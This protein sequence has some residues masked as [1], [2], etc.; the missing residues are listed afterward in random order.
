VTRKNFEDACSINGVQLTQAE[1]N[2]LIEK[3][4]D[5][6]QKIDFDLMSK[7]LKLHSQTIN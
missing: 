7:G 3:Y 4:G 5:G 6:K 1:V 2:E